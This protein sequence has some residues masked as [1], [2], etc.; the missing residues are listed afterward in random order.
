ME[1]RAKSQ[2]QIET[3][4]S[5]PIPKRDK[6]HF[7]KIIEQELFDIKENNYK[8]AIKMLEHEFRDKINEFQDKVDKNFKPKIDPSKSMPPP[9]PRSYSSVCL[10]NEKRI[11]KGL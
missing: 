8:K 3:T 9:M 10:S 1:K 2:S 4:K 5:S 11:E 7:D 6:T